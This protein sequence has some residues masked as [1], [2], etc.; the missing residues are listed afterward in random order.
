MT[1]ISKEVVELLLSNGADPNASD[2]HRNAL[3]H[4][5]ARRGHNDLAELLLA[6]GADPNVQNGLGVSLLHDVAARGQKEFVTLLL[7]RNARV[8]ERTKKG[9]TPLHLAVTSNRREVV[10]SSYSP[11]RPTLMR[12]PKQGKQHCM[13][14]RGAA[15]QTLW[16]Y[17]R[18][19]A[20]K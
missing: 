5:V 8:D 7:A 4:G 1:L 12:G 11:T 2:E 20:P 10:G 15:R 13:A 18:P 3:L 6:N 14:Q 9:Q 19:E 17:S 16:N